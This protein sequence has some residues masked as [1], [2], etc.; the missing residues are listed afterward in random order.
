MLVLVGFH[1]DLL[2]LSG[3]NETVAVARGTKHH[4]L[5]SISFWTENK[6][7]WTELDTTSY[8]RLSHGARK[9]GFAQDPHCVNTNPY[10]DPAFDLNIMAPDLD[11]SAKLMQIWIVA[12][13][14]FAVT[15]KVE[16]LRFLY[17]KQVMLSKKYLGRHEIILDKARSD[18]FIFILAIF[19][20]LDP[21]GSRRAKICKFGF[22]RIWIKNRIWS[23]TQARQKYMFS[24]NVEEQKTSLNRQV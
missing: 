19:L 4:V 15:L 1:L 10:L 13:L 24:P 3:G 2:K 6:N 22:V 20:L 11:Q 7:N 16:F 5:G 12:W 14:G 23:T 17:L 8:Y 9:K 21:V 18:W